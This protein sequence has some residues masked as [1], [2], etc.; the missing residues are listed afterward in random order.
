MPAVLLKPLLHGSGLRCLHEKGANNPCGPAPASALIPLFG[1]GS[2]V[3]LHVPAQAIPIGAAGVF[4][5]EEVFGFSKR[6]GLT[7]PLNVILSQEAGKAV[8]G[9]PPRTVITWR[10]VLQAQ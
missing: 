8:F 4:R 7:N 2:P 3:V 6:I 9:E 10:L 5:F 1:G